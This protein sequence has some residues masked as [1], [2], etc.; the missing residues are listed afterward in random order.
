MSGNLDDARVLLIAI[1]N[2]A[3]NFRQYFIR[4]RRLFDFERF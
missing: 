1:G 2:G 4:T 3:D